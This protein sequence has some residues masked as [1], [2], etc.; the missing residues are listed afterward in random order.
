MS[1]IS[2]AY[3]QALY[4]LAR[5]EGLCQTILPELTALN[6]AMLTEP[7]FLRLLSTPAIPRGER[8]RVLEDSFRGRL[9]PYVLNLLKLLTEKGLMKDFSACAAQYRK[10]HDLD[11]GILPVTVYTAVPLTGE[12]RSRLAQ[13]L[14]SATGRTIEL[15]CRIEPEVLGGVRLEFD[16]RQLDGTL[17]RRLEDVHS[18][19]K[20]TPL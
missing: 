18:I 17:Q 8:L 12:L 5:E 3:G 14:S 15:D 7:D 6:E 20:N 11:R 9:H 1:C 4:D 2:A 10:L 16:G 19:L 13:R